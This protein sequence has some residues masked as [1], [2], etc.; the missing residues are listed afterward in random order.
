MT[1][2]LRRQTVYAHVPVAGRAAIVTVLFVGQ[3]RLRSAMSASKRRAIVIHQARA[4]RHERAV[5]YAVGKAR[6]SLC[7]VAAPVAFLHERLEEDICIADACGLDERPVGGE[8]VTP[9][10]A[11]ATLAAALHRKEKICSP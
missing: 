7:T 2:P 6:Y 3:D 11:D 4:E 5:S 10:C 9:I 1:L 8:A